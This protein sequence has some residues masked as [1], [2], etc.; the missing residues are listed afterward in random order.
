MKVA[1]GVLL[2]KCVANYIAAMQLGIFLHKNHHL[3]AQYNFHYAAK[4]KI[5]ASY[6]LRGIYC[7]TP[8]IGP[9]FYVDALISHRLQQSS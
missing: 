3:L 1:Y 8:L 7:N 6:Q 9:A 2:C 5:T 4:L